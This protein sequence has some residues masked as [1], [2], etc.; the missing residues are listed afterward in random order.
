MPNYALEISG[1]GKSPFTMNGVIAV[2][3]K[4]IKIK[5]KIEA[6]S[7]WGLY[8]K[9]SE[10][11]PVDI[12]SLL[13]SLWSQAELVYT[14]WCPW[15]AM[16]SRA[17]GESGI[18]LFFLLSFLIYCKTRFFRVPFIS[19]ISRARQIRENNGHAKIR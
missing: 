17:F 6:V 4:F 5:R 11:T 1:L 7:D 14:P 15:I 8:E 10:N 16:E 3:S 12:F 18:V 2:H 9:C 19:R 13:S